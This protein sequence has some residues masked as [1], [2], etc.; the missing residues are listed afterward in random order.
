MKA[1]TIV[2]VT[3]FTASLTAP[4]PCSIPLKST[5]PVVSP[6]EFVIVPVFPPVP[7]SP[8]GLGGSGSMTKRFL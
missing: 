8:E 1:S 5:L 6:E 3:L 2:F 4:I 7:V